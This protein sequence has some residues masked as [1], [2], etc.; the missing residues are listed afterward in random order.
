VRAKLDKFETEFY[1][2]RAK[3]YDG[4]SVEIY[5]YDGFLGTQGGSLWTG[6][7]TGDKIQIKLWDDDCFSYY[8]FD[9]T[10]FQVEA[11]MGTTVSMFEGEAFH[12]RDAESGLAYNKAR[13]YNS[14]TGR[15]ITPDPKL[16]CQAPRPYTWG[17]ANP[18]GR[19]D[20]SGE[21]PR[22]EVD[23]TPS[24]SGEDSASTATQASGNS[25]QSS[26]STS[27]TPTANG[28][29]RNS[30]SERPVPHIPLESCENPPQPNNFRPHIQDQLAIIAEDGLGGLTDAG[31]ASCIRNR[32]NFT[33]TIHC[34]DP[35]GLD[36]IDSECRRVARLGVYL[37]W[38]RFWR[39]VFDPF[40]FGMTPNGGKI[41][42][43]QDGLVSPGA[44]GGTTAI[45][46]VPVSE[47]GCTIVHEF[48]HSCGPRDGAVTNKTTAQFQAS[49]FAGC[50]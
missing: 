17:N 9:T 36:L 25:S 34:Q 35:R 16:S 33:G 31:I 41:G 11:D 2:D 21:Q 5:S 49:E 20:A 43:C 48:A 14:T 27:A 4:N 29:H 10:Q 26:T 28:L 22:E 1:W 19:V 30:T 47:V 40:A 6:W 32:I 15:Y 39:T 7:V 42:L 12:L 45:T 24:G 18:I 13:F 38:E 37:G 44:A 50:K 23:R 3:V 46:G 8:G